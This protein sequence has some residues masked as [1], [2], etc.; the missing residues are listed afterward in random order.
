MATKKSQPK[1]RCSGTLTESAYLGKIR[2]LLRKA[3]FIG[4]LLHKLSMLHVG[5]MLGLTSS[6]N[7][8]SSANY[9]GSGGWRSKL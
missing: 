9:V 1:P 3:L 5:N 2:S 6:R 4:S 7:G 8:S